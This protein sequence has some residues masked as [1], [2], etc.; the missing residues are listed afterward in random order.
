[1]IDLS[2]GRSKKKSNI[3]VPKPEMT[4]DKKYRCPI[5]QEVYDNKKDYESHCHEEHD[6]L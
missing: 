3:I 5:D 4:G 2:K 1:V 6:V